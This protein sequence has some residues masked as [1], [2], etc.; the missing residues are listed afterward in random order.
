MEKLEE[1]LKKELK[2]LERIAKVAEA[3]L[4]AAP[5]GTLRIAKRNDKETYYWRTDPKDTKG[6]YVRKN[7]EK[8]IKSL[9]QKDYAKKAMIVLE[10]NI[11]KI[12]KILSQIENTSASEQLIEVYKKF[13]PARQKLITPYVVINDEFAE[14]WEY[15][16]KMWKEKIRIEE[17]FSEPD[18][19]IFTEKGERVR[20]KS[21]KILADKLYMMK[22]PYLYE[23]PLYIQKYGY[24]RPDF[25][26]LNKKTRTEYYWEHLGMMDNE[27]YCE[28]AIRK[29]ESYEKNG[30]FPGKNLILT[31]E[32]KRHPLNTRIVEALAEEY[33]Y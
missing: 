9:G 16:K 19:E 5:Q 10:A 12:K 33:F 32:T 1:F 8:L 29:I 23:V 17:R 18:T 4:K 30:I 14:Q 6:R 27:E 28:K 21:E 2:E 3:D 7:E 13:S 24:I 26:V 22:I 20:S 25:T 11:K 15:G 31:Y